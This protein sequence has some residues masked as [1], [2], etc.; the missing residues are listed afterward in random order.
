MEVE[1]NVLRKAITA[2]RKQQARRRSMPF[3]LVVAGIVM[4]ALGGWAQYRAARLIVDAIEAFYDSPSVAIGV[5]SGISPTVTIGRLL[6]YFG[7][8]LALFGFIRRFYPDPK[9]TV[10]LALLEESTLDG[11]HDDEK[12]A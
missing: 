12:P 8:G 4:A 1:V 3:T 11:E 5:I 6:L 10:L 7:I 9:N 2:L